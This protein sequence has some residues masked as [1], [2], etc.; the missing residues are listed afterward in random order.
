MENLQQ[1]VI[2]R[3]SGKRGINSSCMKM[4]Y[5]DEYSDEYKGEDFI[6]LGI[7]AQGERCRMANCI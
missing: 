5:Y 3:K 6:L 1:W 7:G 4:R 2:S